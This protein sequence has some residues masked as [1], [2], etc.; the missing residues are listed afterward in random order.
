MQMRNLGNLEVSA[1]G[2]N[3]PRT[4]S[5]TRVLTT[6]EL[7]SLCEKSGGKLKLLNEKSEKLGNEIKSSYRGEKL[8]KLFVA[9]AFVFITIEILLTKWLK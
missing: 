5:D 7:E 8:W 2:L 4:E 1:I 9:L 3:L 6:K